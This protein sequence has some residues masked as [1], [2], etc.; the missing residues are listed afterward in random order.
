MVSWDLGYMLVAKGPNVS[1]NV[2]LDLRENTAK[3][4]SKRTR[5]EIEI[6]VT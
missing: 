6:Q 1:R 4:V 2:E 5:G 3:G